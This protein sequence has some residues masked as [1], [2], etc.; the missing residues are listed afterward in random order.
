M[1]DNDAPAALRLPARVG[2]FGGETFRRSSVSESMNGAARAP[3]TKGTAMSDL[4]DPM[5]HQFD[6]VSF[7][8]ADL[9]AVTPDLSTAPELATGASADHLGVLHGSPDSVADDWF[10]QRDQGYCLPASVTQVL[11][12]V[13]GRSLPDESVVMA[14]VEDLGLPFGSS[15]MQMA[16]GVTLLEHFG[17]DA[18]IESGLSLDDLKDFLDD[19]RSVI[20][21]VDAFNIW[22]GKD[23]PTENPQDTANHALLITGIDTER[24]YVVLSDPGNPNGNEDVVQLSDFIEAWS[25]SG[26]SAIVTTGPTPDGQDVDVTPWPVIL[27]V[28]VNADHATGSQSYTVQAGDTLWDIA[29]RVYGNGAEFQKIADASGI[30]NPD[31]ILPGQQLTIPK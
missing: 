18:E 15:G 19:G 25:D 16:D 30:T 26:N 6:A 9:G 4:H 14:A 24:G 12:E 7:D 21:G 5:G 11:S 22:D 27:P 2:Y 3:T 31:L 20:L 1:A 17:I 10:L 28:T 13:T 23:N 29:E 8:P